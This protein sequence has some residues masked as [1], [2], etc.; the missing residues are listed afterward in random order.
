MAGFSKTGFGGGG[1][2][3]LVMSPEEKQKKGA[4]G[5]T[6]YR[7]HWTEV[8]SFREEV[9]DDDGQHYSAGGSH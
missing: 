2:G 3:G 5:Q 7:V 9:P 1:G 4:N 6:G 8:P